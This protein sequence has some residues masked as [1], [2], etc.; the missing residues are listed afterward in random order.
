MHFSE[1]GSGK[2]DELDLWSVCLSV[3][4]ALGSLGASRL[5]NRLFT[6]GAI[7]VRFG[8]QLGDHFLDVGF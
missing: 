5:L 8:V 4:S 7:P 1:V 2:K 3:L 6:A